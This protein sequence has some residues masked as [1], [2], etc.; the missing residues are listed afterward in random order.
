MVHISRRLTAAATEDEEL[1]AN[2]FASACA[3]G[4]SSPGAWTERTRP[5]FSAS[6]APNSSAVITHSC[7]CCMPTSRG[8][9]QHEPASIAMP[10]LLNTKPMRADA[11]IIRT[12]MGRHMVMPTPTAAPLIAATIGFRQLKIASV[13]ESL[14]S[15]FCGLLPSFHT[16]KAPLPPE[17][18]APAL[19]ALSLSGRLSVTVITPSERSVSKVSYSIDIIAPPGSFRAA[20]RNVVARLRGLGNIRR[21]P[22][23]PQSR[24]KSMSHLLKSV[25]D[26]VMKIVLNRPEAMNALSRDM[27]TGLTDALHEAAGSREVGCVVV[28]GA[29]DKAFCAGGDVKSMA[30]GRDQDKTYED[31]VH[32]IRI[33]MQVSELLHEMGKPTIAMVNG[34]AAGAGLSLALA[35]DMRFAGKSARMT[36]AFAKVGFSGDFGSHYFLHK[37]V[38]TAKARELYFT[39]EIL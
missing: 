1:A 37:L 34:V 16:W 36:T 12:S 28:R 35:A 20:R 19:K 11:D 10:R 6:S 27:M 39:A 2:F 22:S 15:R 9:N 23:D 25:E 17:M 33:R 26:G 14:A 18:S 29:G 21:K 7:A 24:R 8:R 30:A 5:P 31:K 13:I 3:A 4:K 38:G 32:D